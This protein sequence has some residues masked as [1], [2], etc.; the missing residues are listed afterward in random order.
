LAEIAKELRGDKG[1]EHPRGC[2]E[3]LDDVKWTSCDLIYAF[4]KRPNCASPWALATFI[5]FKC[6]TNHLGQSTAEGI[7]AGFQ[8]YWDRAQVS[9]SLASYT[10][11]GH[12]SSFY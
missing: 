1:L 7:H 2:P 4:D 10:G 3:G 5:S 9:L 8:K 11:F 12:L 6:F